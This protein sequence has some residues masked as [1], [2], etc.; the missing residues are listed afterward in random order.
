MKLVVTSILHL[1]ESGI[2]FAQSFSSLDKQT[3]LTYHDFY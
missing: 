1:K 3:S 2:I